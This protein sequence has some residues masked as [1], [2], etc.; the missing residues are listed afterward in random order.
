MAAISC[1]HVTGHNFHPIIFKFCTEVEN[2]K[3]WKWFNF[4]EKKSKMA[5]VAAILAKLL[6]I[7]CDHVTGHNFHPI[8]FKFCIEVENDDFWNWFNFG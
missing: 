4:G 7:S 1:V 2:D 6:D 3:F 8:T 5:A